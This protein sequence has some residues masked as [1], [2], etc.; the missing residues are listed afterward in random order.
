MEAWFVGLFSPTFSLV[1]S[2]HLGYISSEEIC[3]HVQVWC[4]TLQQ[5]LTGKGPSALNFEERG[6]ISS[7]ALPLFVGQLAS[8]LRVTS[9]STIPPH[10]FLLFSRNKCSHRTPVAT[11]WLWEHELCRV[12]VLLCLRWSSLHFFSY[13]LLCT[14][15]SFMWPLA[16]KYIK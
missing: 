4:V 7:I 12:S 3:D 13:D 5:Q 16:S 8:H 11:P 6:G 9:A 10:Q 1:S 14:W 2:S 15:D